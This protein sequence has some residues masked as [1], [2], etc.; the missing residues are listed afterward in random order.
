MIYSFP[1]NSTSDG[2]GNDGERYKFPWINYAGYTDAL[3]RL[4]NNPSAAWYANAV[5]KSVGKDIADDAEFRWFRIR[6][7]IKKQPH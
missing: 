5:A 6:D 4:T 1:P 2:F 7:G 3:A